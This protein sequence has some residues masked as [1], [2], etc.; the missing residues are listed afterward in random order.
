[1]DGRTTLAIMCAAAGGG[2][3][4]LSLGVLV[5]R[6]RARR[7]IDAPVAP[8]GGWRVPKDR[9]AFPGEI[10]ASEKEVRSLLERGVR[11]AEPEVRISAVTTLG[12][13]GDRYE[14]AIDGLIEALAAGVEH[15][16]RVAA[17]LDRLAP[18]PGRRLTPLL[19][20]PSDQVRFC[21]IRLL[22]SYPALA[23]SHAPDLTFDLS[24]NVRAAALETLRASAS[25][26]ALRCSL[27]L[28]DD[29]HSMVR[30]HACRT[31][32]TVAGATS[33]P[34]VAT[35]LGYGTPLD[36]M[37]ARRANT[38]VKTAIVA[39]GCAMAQPMPNS[40]WLYRPF[41]SRR[42]RF[43]SSS[44]YAAGSIGS[45]RSISG[46]DATVVVTE[47]EGPLT[48][49]GPRA[50]RTGTGTRRRA[51]SNHL[52]IVRDQCEVLSRCDPAVHGRP[53]SNSNGTARD[54]RVERV[55]T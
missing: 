41:T 39:S 28:L 38:N 29:P 19:G 22:A 20:H 46:R 43:I 26:E 5:G 54:N 25:A 33:A 8:A 16:V 12:R 40:D 14:W 51:R 52:R 42:V 55:A 49:T 31:A 21:A 4:L 9:P 37:F 34:F 10:G 23:R 27:R 45:A 53:A 24:P 30:A 17:Q 3:L 18:R 1:M 32:S 6:L 47:P 11:S 2:W 7:T 35:L 44:Q 13:L 36:V 48:R 15:P 50:V